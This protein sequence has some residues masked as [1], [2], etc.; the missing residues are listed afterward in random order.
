MLSLI[1]ID[2]SIHIIYLLILMLNL[3]G[4]LYL[5]FLTQILIFYHIIYDFFNNMLFYLII[6][7]FFDLI[8]QLLINL[9]FTYFSSLYFVHHLIVLILNS[10]FL[11]YIFTSVL[12]FDIYFLYSFIVDPNFYS[13]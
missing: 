13:L 7:L 12:S 9:N 10:I 2:L 3:V 11:S 4:L 6:L 1:I 8:I 5:Y